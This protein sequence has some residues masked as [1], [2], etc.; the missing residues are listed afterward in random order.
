MA[1]TAAA[2][3]RLANVLFVASS[4]E[5]D[6]GGDDL[7]GVIGLEDGKVSFSQ[8]DVPPAG[9]RFY[10]ADGAACRHPGGVP[11][12][13][14]PDAL[15]PRPTQNEPRSPGLGAKNVVIDNDR[16]AIVDPPGT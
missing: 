4:V 10:G 3:C 13:E 8:I 1:G 5:Q 15:D 7:S 6:P 16:V 14:E 12:V 9:R 11:S 2:F